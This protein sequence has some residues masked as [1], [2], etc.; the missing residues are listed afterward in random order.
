VEVIG[1]FSVLGAGRVELCIGDLTTMRADDAVDL[2]VVSA[3][4][5]DYVPTRRSLV[6]ALARAGLSVANLASDKLDDMRETSSCWLSMR[7]PSGKAMFGIGQVL[8]YEPRKP[9]VAA[10]SVGDVFRALVP[11]VGGPHGVQTVAMPVL[12]S[13]DQGRGLDEMLG[14]ILDAATGWM[15]VRLPLARLRIVVRPDQADGALAAWASWRDSHRVPEPAAVADAD[16]PYDAFISYASEDATD[17]AAEFAEGLR[18]RK[19]SARVFV[20]RNEIDPGAS[21]QQRIYDCLN[22]CR[23]VVV[24][25]T[26]G[27]LH[28]KV[29]EEEL[30]LARLRHRESATGVLFPLY[31]RSADLET[32]AHI[33]MLDYVDCREASP[34][35]IRQACD[36][37]AS[38][39][40]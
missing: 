23:K 26:P 35:A 17:L 19:P 40:Y 6:G 38:Q 7:I 5:D 27:Y 39:L 1:A 11:F 31:V 12:A 9:A 30:N 2:L 21:W 32:R 4:P 3:F 25:I 10:V 15:G 33:R 18:L 22:V 36:A 8:C 29:C 24:M 13:G 16:R 20:Y 37:L 34:E 28:S 14:A